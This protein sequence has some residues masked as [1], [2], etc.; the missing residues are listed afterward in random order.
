MCSKTV[1]SPISAWNGWLNLR[2]AKKTKVAASACE[3][4]GVRVRM[5][6]RLRGRVVQTGM[7][8][9]FV[10]TVRGLALLAECKDDVGCRE[11]LCVCVCVCVC[12]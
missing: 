1:L 11:R 6:A 4:R 3:R 8:R 5:R 10:C 12:V 2:S 7:A 9:W